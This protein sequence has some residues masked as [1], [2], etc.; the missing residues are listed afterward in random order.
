[1]RACEHTRRAPGHV[2]ALTGSRE[3]TVWP[4]RPRVWEL[5]PCAAGEVHALPNGRSRA[6][7]PR[8]RRLSPR[9]LGAS[10]TRRAAL[11]WQGKTV[12]PGAS[13]ETGLLPRGL[14]HRGP[15]PWNACPVPHRFR[16]PTSALLGLSVPAAQRVQSW[17]PGTRL[18]SPKPQR[19]PE[20]GIGDGR[21]YF[22]WNSKQTQW[23]KIF[24]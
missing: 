21:V 3:P 5:R 18:A 11:R 19:S 6:L 17:E 20:G 7:L 16:N 24:G 2:R 12:R 23:G 14:V 15:G 10:S 4:H 1:M 8:A 13:A 22:L 9:R